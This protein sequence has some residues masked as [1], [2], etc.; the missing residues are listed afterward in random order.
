MQELNDMIIYRSRRYTP[1]CHCVRKAIWKEKQGIEI[2]SLSEDETVPYG[3]C[4]HRFY[5]ELSVT[6]MAQ[7]S[8]EIDS[9]YLLEEAEVLTCRKS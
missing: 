4:E 9:R 8:W 5:W 6:E 2:V 3:E 1:P 7:L